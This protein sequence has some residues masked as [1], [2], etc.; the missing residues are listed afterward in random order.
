MYRVFDSEKKIVERVADVLVEDVS[1]T[2]EQVLF[3]LPSEEQEEES[4]E[5]PSKE[6][7]EFQVKND[8]SS[9]ESDGNHVDEEEDAVH[10]SSELQRKRERPLG[11]RSYQKPVSTTDRV[12]RDRSKSARIIAMKVSLD[13]ISYKDAI[14]RDDSISWKQVIDEEMSSLIKNQTWELKSLPVGQPL[15]SCQ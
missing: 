9:D 10:S 1:D 13:P 14:A 4:K 8:I 7:Q 6:F 11:S 12:L 3:P 5:S 2:V 15:V